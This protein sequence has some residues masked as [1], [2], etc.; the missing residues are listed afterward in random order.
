MCETASNSFWKQLKDFLIS[1]LSL[2][3]KPM[4]GVDF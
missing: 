1:T 3:I 4:D 2:A